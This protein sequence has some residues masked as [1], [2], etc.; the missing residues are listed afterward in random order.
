[1]MMALCV[2]A[3]LTAIVYG[4]IL[5]FPFLF[6]DIIHLRWLEGRPTLSVWT[7]AKRMQH[8]RPLVTF[9]WALSERA[10]GPH[11]P[12]PLHLLTLL[13]HVANG[14]LVA[15]LAK[16]LISGALAPTAA[17]A[18]FV[19]YP[20]S[21]QVMPSPGSQSKP[22]ST[23]FVLVACLLY[24]RGREQ[25][26]P[27][28]VLGAVL[29]ATLAPFAYEA[30]ITAG[31][32]LLLIEWLLWRQG[33]VKGISPWSLALPVVGLPFLVLWQVVPSSFDPVVFP[34]WEAL[35]QSS[36]Y[37]V[38]GLTWPVTL[39][40]K[41]L[42]LATRLSDGYAA[43]L[44]GYA[45]LVTIIVLYVRMRRT[46]FLLFA[47]GWFG[48][49]L[50][51][52]WVS[53]SFRYVIDGPRILY[54]ASA[55]MALL[56]ADLIHQAG[57]RND[58]LGRAGRVVSVVSLLAMVA[59]GA[60]FG[61]ERMSLV[62]DGSS[63]LTTASSRARRSKPGE[64]GLF[65]NIPAWITVTE[66]D[67]AL[68]HEGYTLLPPYYAVG[69]GDFARVNYGLVRDMRIGA[70]AD[71]RREWRA[72]IGYHGQRVSLE[73]L[74]EQIRASHYVMALSYSG[75]GLRLVDVGGVVQPAS[76]AKRGEELARF[77]DAIALRQAQV[78]QA[79]GD[80]P[81]VELVWES[82]KALPGPH[83]IF[84]HVYTP[85][86]QLVAQADG[87][88]LGGTY[89]PRLWQPGELVEDLRYPFAEPGPGAVGRGF[90][91]GIGLYRPDTGERVPAYDPSGVR[92]PD[93]VYRRPLGPS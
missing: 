51:V 71:I 70:L 24:W 44:V 12:F 5:S 86:G 53:L 36:I 4:I 9:I 54:G 82:L 56:W 76:T 45:I 85:D 8:Y 27:R 11:N 41:R 73:E 3:A 47:L 19:T 1:M 35:W 80:L 2:S 29:C 78:V 66:T 17:A 50:I 64:L 93:D 38:Q 20:L 55:G 63:V 92:L 60:R 28:W 32:F 31:G 48:L 84:V 16:R 88:A 34:G 67:F 69:L 42:M 18:L 61:L 89:P 22:V 26:R 68:G 91:L 79:Q 30:A 39:I 90:E 49:S 6:D 37:F 72:R 21:Y 83:T 40:A 81:S 52:Q 46:T 87:Y 15:W 57:D 58:Q 23:L 77:G 10:L 62:A 75:R 59:W 33:T 74:A 13:L 43:A 25:G 14:C 7:S 65:V